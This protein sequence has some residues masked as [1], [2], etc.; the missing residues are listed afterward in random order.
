MDLI[1]VHK[2]IPYLNVVFVPL[3]VTALDVSENPKS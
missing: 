1:K 2:L 3:D